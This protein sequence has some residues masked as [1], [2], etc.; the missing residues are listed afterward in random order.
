M[1]AR[2]ESR[3]VFVLGFGSGITAGALL[4]YPVQRVTVA[5]NCAAVLKAAPIFSP[6]NRGVLTNRLTRIWREDARTILKLSPQRYDVII[7]EPSNPWTVGIGSVFSQEF[8]EL[9][10]SRLKPGGLMA[11]WFHAYE[12]NDDI[13][14]LVLRTFGSVFPYL[15]IWDTSP[16]DLV[17]LGSKSPWPSSPDIYRRAMSREPTRRDLERIGL[18]NAESIWARQIASQRTG[19]A[20]AGDGLLQ[21]DEFPILEYEAPKAFYIGRSS[22]LINDYD[23][24]T[25]QMDLSALQKWQTLHALSEA[26]LRAIFTEYGSMNPD[27]TRYF[28]FRFHK[29]MSPA[30]LDVYSGNRLM[31]CVFRPTEDWALPRQMLA[32]T[33]TVEKQLWQAESELLT[34]PNDSRRAVEEITRILRETVTATKPQT[35]SWSPAF[36]AMLAAKASINQ[37]DWTQAQALLTLGRQGESGNKLLSYV[38]RVLERVKN[39]DSSVSPTLA[40]QMPTTP[41]MK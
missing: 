2:P 23:E 32:P 6:W 17:L 28:S 3:E 8:F 10:A 35:N 19:F 38:E 22:R 14:T 41:N 36:Y 29:D 20:I 16:G 30:N 12:V 1:V 24:R 13:V 9:A 26:T 5:E 11:Q 27:L 25:W 40:N 31:P 34:R 21:S 4:G 39:A 33:N 18:K 15:E 7:S 37:G